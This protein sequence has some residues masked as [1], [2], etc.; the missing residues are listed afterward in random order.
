MPVEQNMKWVLL[1]LDG[2]IALSGERSI[3]FSTNPRN[4]PAAQAGIMHDEIIQPIHTLVNVLAKA[5]HKIIVMSARSE[6]CIEITKKW[7]IANGIPFDDIVMKGDTDF[8]KDYICKQ[9]MLRKLVEKYGEPL[10]ALEDRPDV[11]DMFRQEGVFSL[12]V[13]NVAKIAKED[14]NKEID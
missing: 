1:D 14:E 11:V 3:F 5:G 2:T 4:Y 8:R 6:G 9:E 13:N 12:L 7:L 10:L